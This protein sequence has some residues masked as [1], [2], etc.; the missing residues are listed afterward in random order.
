M[1]DAKEDNKNE[2]TLANFRSVHGYEIKTSA[3]NEFAGYLQGQKL[4]ALNTTKAATRNI[5]LSVD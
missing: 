2:Q 5:I 1:L 3:R 4:K